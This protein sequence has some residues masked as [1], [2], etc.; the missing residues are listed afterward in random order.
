MKSDGRVLKERRG[1]GQRRHEPSNL[2]DRSF[3]TRPRGWYRKV[4]PARTRV[5]L[6]FL[7][8]QAVWLSRHREGATGDRHLDRGLGT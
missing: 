3:T 6:V 5:R 8:D 1:V 4:R 2:V 7:L